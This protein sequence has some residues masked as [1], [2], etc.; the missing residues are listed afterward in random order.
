MMFCIT[1][2]ELY[3]MAKPKTFF[4]NF[5]RT[6]WFIFVIACFIYV[7]TIP[8]KWAIDD[9]LIIHQNKFVQK[10]IS[11]ILDILTKD[12][13]AGFYGEDVNAVA[14][15][16]YR[17]LTPALFALQAEVFASTKKDENQKIEKDKE[18]FKIKDLSEN[19]WFPNV[20]HFFN[21]FW[22]GLLCLVLYRTLLLLFNA[23]DKE[24]NFKTNFLAIATSLLFAVHPLH[25]EA[26][27][28]VK[29]L[30]EILALLGALLSLYCVLKVYLISEENNTSISKTKWVIGAVV[31]YFLALFSKESSV[32]FMVVIPLA[33]WFF[34]QASVK[35]IFK[36]TFPLV[37]PLVLFL[38][39]RTAVLHQPNKGVVAE[40]LMNNPFLVLDSAS[41][42]VPLIQGSSIKKLV[43]SNA[44]TFTKMPYSNELATNFY[45]YGVYLKLLI[46][47]VTLTC[48]YY[49]RYIEIKSFADI[50]VILSLL[51]HLFLLIWALFHIRKKNTIAFGILYY[52]I[53]FSIVSNLFFPIGTNMAE[54]F[55]FMPSVGFCLVAACLL[56]ELGNKLSQPKTANGFSKIY[57][58]LTIIVVVFSTLT[59]KR[60]FDWKDNL[61]LFSKD[62][63]VSKNSGKINT[64]LAA[65][66]INKAVFIKEEKLK[67]IERLSAEEKKDALKSIDQ[68]RNQ[69]F[70]NAIPL[71]S[72]ALEIH[73]MSNLAWLKMANANHFLGQSEDNDSKTNLM[74]LQTA[75][76]A[77]NE[78]YFYR[79]KGMD[80]VVNNYK[81]ICLMD[82]G[83]LMGQKFG[84][85]PSAIYCLEQA[86]TLAPDEP[87]VYMLLGTAYSFFNQYE[88]AIEYS[89][90]SLEL[91]PKDRDTKQNLAVACQIYAK[92]NPLK[93]DLLP[94]AEKLLLEVYNEEKQL[95]D[96]VSK[97]ASM[98]RTLDLLQKNYALQSNQAKQVEIAAIL[99]SL[100]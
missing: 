49:P 72:K 14:G 23:R 86:K 4:N 70:K 95:N 54:R 76:A 63:L 37:I 8:N 11:G 61:T 20:L 6:Q 88:K 18:G 28:N 39:I 51:I 55:M 17:P 34:T 12:A 7:N 33:L 74:Y 82:L 52:C 69:L 41:Q 93:K 9:S 85:I 13:F 68:E 31:A 21:M 83:K 25:T 27:A 22:Y 36:V 35:T 19:T 94:K 84:D 53:T 62:I 3:S 77:Y 10:G 90:K 29:G 80:T 30:D 57:F 44:N 87:E 64:D 81:A 91:R 38:G 60:N 79:G 58:I 5:K 47:P 99:K 66:Y 50:S 73:P 75:I 100:N 15:G 97:K 98:I 92:A 89:E 24:K 71:L 26:V 2:Y 45:T 40:E 65:E 78:A 56:F 43:N 96:D 67:E 59:I 16:R 42:Y 48:D 32:T 1:F 46:A